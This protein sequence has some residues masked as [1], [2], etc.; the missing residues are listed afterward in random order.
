[1]ECIFTEATI[2]QEVTRQ[3][4]KKLVLFSVRRIL[5]KK[6]HPGRNNSEMRIAHARWTLAQE[7]RL[8]PIKKQEKYEQKVGWCL[9]RIPFQDHRV[10]LREKQKLKPEDFFN[11]ITNTIDIVPLTKPP[12]AQA[13]SNANCPFSSNSRFAAV[14]SSRQPVAPNGCPIDSEPPQRLNFSSG[15]APTCKGHEL[16]RWS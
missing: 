13:A 3:F 8:F 7:H 4:N 12:A 11:N 10:A 14:V 1:M 16:T 2:K 5:H 9:V 6:L 15:G